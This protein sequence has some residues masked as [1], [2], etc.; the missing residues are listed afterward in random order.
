MQRTRDATHEL[1]ATHEGDPTHGRGVLTERCHHEGDVP[2][3]VMPP[4]DVIATYGYG[5]TE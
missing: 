3:E 2:T 1:D 5:L 4:T